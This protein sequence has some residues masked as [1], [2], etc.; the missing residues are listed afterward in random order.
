MADVP[1]GVRRVGSGQL[2]I[3]R[4]KRWVIAAAIAGL[5]LAYSVFSGSVISSSALLTALVALAAVLTLVLRS[6]GFGMDHPL[7]QPLATRPWRSGQDVL[8]L[9]LRN[10]R[11]VFIVTPGGSL[12]A[13]SSVELCMNPA[14]VDSLA[15]AIDLDLA[16][17]F[18]VEAYEAAV[19]ACN[20]RIF[21]NAPVEV[22]VI[23]DADVPVGR[24]QVR[25]RRQPT[26]FGPAGS[27]A[28]SVAAPRFRHGL[29]TLHHPAPAG[30]LLTGEL[31]AVGS[32]RNPLL[33]LVTGPAVTETRMSEARAGRARAAELTLPDELT[34][35]RLH[36][37][38]RCSDGEWWI[39]ALGR[40]GVVLNGVVLTGEHLLR[41]GD[42]I[43]WGR[44][45]DAPISRV[46]IL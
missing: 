27:G 1:N 5:W 7:L 46:E 4:R 37:R 38:L 45:A 8:Q 22:R 2:G 6:L 11:Q 17:A 3:R 20:A 42:R 29:T 23:E 32:A 26:A 19:A 28:A 25:Q 30:T 43:R 12:L 16:N 13:P 34:V 21:R 39:T 40:N 14:D 15:D 36:A 24:Y 33:R 31:T 9:A 44:Q 18:A 10:L 41:D 35:S